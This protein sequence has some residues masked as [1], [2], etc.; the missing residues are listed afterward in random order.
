MKTGLALLAVLSVL[1][2]EDKKPRGGL[3]AWRNDVDNA[4]ADA[5][6]GHQPVIMYFTHDR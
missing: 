3:V 4:L 5:R 2:A 1:A 6:K